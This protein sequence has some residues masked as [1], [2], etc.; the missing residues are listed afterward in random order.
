MSGLGNKLEV[1]WFRGGDVNNL[2]S[3]CNL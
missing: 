2:W 1:D 3:Q